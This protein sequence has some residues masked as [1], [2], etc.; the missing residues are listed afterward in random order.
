MKIHQLRAGVVLL[1]CIVLTGLAQVDGE[2]ATIKG[3]VVDLWC[4]L[5]DGGRGKEHKDCA[6]A[7]AKAGNPIGLVTETG[8]IYLLMSDKE[9]QPGREELTGQMAAQVAVSGR[10]CKRNGITALYFTS[11]T[12]VVP[13]TASGTEK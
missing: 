5:K 7:C 6:I 12:P 4:Y 9:R 13:W 2:S 1:L 3:E 10:L 8:A 11:L